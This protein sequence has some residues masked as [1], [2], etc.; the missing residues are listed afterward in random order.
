MLL[1][2]NDIIDIIRHWLSTPSNA[3]FGESYGANL[4]SFLL[5]PMTEDHANRFIDKLYKDIP[6]FANQDIS[7]WQESEDH[8]TKIIYLKIGEFA[9]NLNQF[10]EK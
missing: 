5:R 10:I 9:I 6:M 3:Y 7:L 4:T 2:R 1:E 8:D